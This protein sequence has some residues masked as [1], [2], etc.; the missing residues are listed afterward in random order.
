MSND[1]LKHSDDKADMSFADILNEF[2]STSQEA[3]SKTAPTAKGKGKGRG[4][5]PVQ[6]LR[7]TVVGVSGDF[8][9]VDYGAKS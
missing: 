1:P 3:R 9:L 5:P 2:E 8:V 7:G 6:G 4:R